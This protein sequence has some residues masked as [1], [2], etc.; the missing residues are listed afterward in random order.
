[1]TDQITVYSYD[2]ASKEYRGEAIARKDPLD[3]KN[4]ILPANCTKIAPNLQEGYLSV[5]QDNVWENK[6][7]LPEPVLIKSL[8]EL[9]DDKKVILSRLVS[10]EMVKPLFCKNIN[11]E[12]CYI[13][14]DKTNKFLGYFALGDNPKVVRYF[15]AVSK[16]GVRLSHDLKLNKAELKKLALHYEQREDQLEEIE[17]KYIDLID[18]AKTKTAL[19]NI[20]FE[21]LE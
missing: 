7:I 15:R 9:K 11:D 10:V 5:W 8:Q 4:F 17:N 20:K 1:M 19:S 14:T 12:G 18:A 6:E 13:S 21:E 3:P 16:E 2:G